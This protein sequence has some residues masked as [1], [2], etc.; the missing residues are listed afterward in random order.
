VYFLRLNFQPKPEIPPEVSLMHRFLSALLS[1]LLVA[2]VPAAHAAQ[3]PVE[4]KQYVRLPSPQHTTVAPGKV[5]VLEVFSYGCPACN[6]FQPTMEKLRHDLPP[7]A[8]MSFLPAAFNTAED[9][10]ML[11]RAYFAAQFLGVAERTHQ[12]MYDAV[13]KSGELAISDPTTNRLKNPLPSL[14]DAAKF[15]Q[16]A[17]GVSPEKFLQVARSFGVDAKIRAADAQIQAMEIPG[18]PSIV[19]NGKY[20]V[21]MDSISSYDELINVVRYLIAQESGQH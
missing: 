9:W 15:Y 18:T 3:S 10:P 1:T 6:H 16:K 19:I 12:A 13:W 20:R 7:N 8:Q 11:Q 4:G 5:E 2:L 21:L 14:E 17:A